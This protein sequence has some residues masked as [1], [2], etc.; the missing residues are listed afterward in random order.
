MISLG[1]KT[2]MLIGASKPNVPIIEMARSMGYRVVVTDINPEAEGLKYGDY[3]YNVS[4]KDIETLAKIALRHGVCCA[5][6]GTDIN[7]SVGVINETMGL[8]GF[9]LIMGLAS[10]YKHIFR[11]I[12]EGAGMPLTRGYVVSNE[13]EAMDAY[14]AIGRGSVVVKAVDLGSSLGIKKVSSEDT[15][16]DAIKECGELTEERIL[17]VEEYIEGSSHDVN[18]LV[19]EGRF[20]PCGIVD[21][22]FVE[23]GEY[24][25]QSE[26]RCPTLLPKEVQREAYSIMERFCKYLD[27]HTSPVKADFLFDGK[28]LYLLEFAPRFHGE[29]GFLHIIP[30]AINIRAM[31]AYLRYRYDGVLDESLLEERIIDRALCRARIKGGERSNYDVRC[32]TISFEKKEPIEVNIR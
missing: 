31:E 18:G 23:K 24:F 10:E 19:V 1:E 9:P 29:M 27:V 3:N 22:A 6:S 25:V 13:K 32:Y 11:K 7:L 12:A 21:R 5:Y 30:G 4:A 15:L 2:F 20:Y 17:V 8:Q 26:I 16:R 28:R 14:R